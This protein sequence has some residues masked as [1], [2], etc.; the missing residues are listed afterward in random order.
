M[1]D[2][3]I[4]SGTSSFVEF[5][6]FRMEQTSTVQAL[7]TINLYHFY[8]CSMNVLKDKFPSRADD[9]FFIA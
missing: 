2:R 7:V 1:E 6:S 5:V 3:E 4:T 9:A 8:Q